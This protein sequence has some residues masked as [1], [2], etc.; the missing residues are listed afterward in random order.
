MGRSAKFH[1]RVKKTA[2]SS[3][4]QSRPAVPESR[5]KTSAAVGNASSSVQSAK[6]RSDLKSK[7]KARP[8]TKSVEGEHVLGG[9]DYV[10]LLLGGRRKAAEE[11]LKLPKEQ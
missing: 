1:K 5:T 8:G 10:T 6:K 11:A 3:N 9:A 2:S 4:A 7:V